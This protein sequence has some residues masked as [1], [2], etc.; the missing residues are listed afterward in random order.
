MG[1]SSRRWCGQLQLPLAN[2]IWFD[3]HHLNEVG[4]DVLPDELRHG[5]RVFSDDFQ[6]VS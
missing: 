4:V 5:V 6:F 1:P 3:L 2:A